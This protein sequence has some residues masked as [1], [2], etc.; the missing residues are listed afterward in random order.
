MPAGRAPHRYE[1]IAADLRDAI[2]SGT[3]EEGAQLPGENSIMKTYD[4]ARATARDALAVLRHEGLAVA[5]P[6]A[7][8]FVA[9]RHRIMRDST[10]RYSRARKETPS[11]FRSDT[12]RAGQHG[13]WEHSSQKTQA[14]PE[15]ARRLHL[16]PGE[17]VMQTT[18]RYFSNDQ[19]IQLSQS[20]EPLAITEG[21]PI[22]YPE[23]GAAVGVITRM[24]LI[25]YHINQVVERVTARA[26]K[27]IEIT[28]LDLPQRGAYV[29][30]IDRTYY[31]DDRPIETCDIIFPGDRYELTY[32]IPV[33]D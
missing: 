23:E 10:A 33:P 5:R 25:G 30:V 13:H 19:P 29:L 2:L 11:P 4:V 17:P 24:D 16:P 26:A 9:S 28:Q 22:E 20:W 3:Y 15:I 8:V 12:K 14:N 7:G 18:Y 21:T 32:T 6:G 1:E 27:P 31:A